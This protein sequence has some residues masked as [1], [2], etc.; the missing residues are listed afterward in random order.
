LA[1]QPDRQVAGSAPDLEHPGVGGGDAGDVGGDALDERAEQEPA[2]SVVED[3][4]ANEDAAWHLV[5]SGG[6]SA[7]S[8]DGDGRGGRAGQDRQGSRS[9]HDTSIGYPNA[10]LGTAEQ[11]LRL[12]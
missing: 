5:P 12:R 10:L 11:E 3:G 4:I 2:Q 8:Q 6:M 9:D 1:S 7:M